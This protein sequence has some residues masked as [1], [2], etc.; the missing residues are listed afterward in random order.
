M[1]YLWKE[2]YAALEVKH[3]AFKMYKGNNDEVIFEFMNNK[4]V[5]SDNDSITINDT[6]Y[7]SVQHA[8]SFIKNY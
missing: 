4:I 3:I 1:K 6:K 2:V 5:L 8:V 7:N